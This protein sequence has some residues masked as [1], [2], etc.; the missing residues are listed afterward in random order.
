MKLQSINWFWSS[1]DYL[2]DDM[3]LQNVFNFD[4]SQISSQWGPKKRQIKQIKV[5]YYK[6]WVNMYGIELWS[7]IVDYDESQFL[8]H[9]L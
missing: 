4:G 2:Y 5:A 6:K 9:L 8:T 3:D 1:I 7:K